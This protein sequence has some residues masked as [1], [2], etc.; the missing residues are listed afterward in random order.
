MNAALRQDN[1]K[2]L[3]KLCVFVVAMFGFG[4]ALVPFYEKICE[5]TG[6]RNIAQA[7]V[8]KN[9]QVDTTRD[10]RIEFDS[11]IR[12]LPWQFRALTPV[13]AVHPGEVR[14]VVFEIVNTTDRSLTGQAIPS[15]GPPQAA[16]YFRKLECFCF[17][18]QTLQPGER[19][20]MPVVFVVDASLPADVVTITLSYTFFEVEGADKS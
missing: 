6:L 19:R 11:N 5:A 2:L 4:Y 18:R 16:Q 7:D 14:E 8:V 15:Y 10:V 20:E 3:G 1:R 13:V 17:A 12:K 9:T